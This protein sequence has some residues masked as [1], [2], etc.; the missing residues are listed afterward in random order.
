VSRPLASRLQV[1]LLGALV[2]IACF[3][4]LLFLV[5]AFIHPLNTDFAAFYALSRLGLT[6]GWGSLYDQVAEHEAWAAVGPMRFYPDMYP[7]T[8]S[9]LLAPVA[10]LPLRVAYALWTATSLG[11]LLWSWHTLAQGRLLTRALQLAAACALLP[12]G[13][14]IFLGQ[15]VIFI[16]AAITLAWRLLAAGRPYLAGLALAALSVKPQI[17]L[18]VPVALLLAGYGRTFLAG[19]G[20]GVVLLLL[21]WLTLGFDGVAAYVSHLSAGMAEPDRYGVAQGLSFWGLIGRGP[22]ALAAECGA[23]LLALIAAWRCRGG[24]PELPIAAGIVGSLVA[25][26][27]IHVQDAS[28]LLIAGW[29]TLRRRGSAFQMAILGSAYVAADLS[30]SVIG[31]VPLLAVEIVWLLDLVRSP[32]ARPQPRLIAQEA[33]AS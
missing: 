1:A 10:L 8:L 25:T 5:N 11:L 18:L 30:A 9:W 32:V 2:A 16:G 31:P 17:A 26:P 14:E 21:A 7:P 20:A 12:V 19:A 33:P 6:H 15:P 28:L 27:F 23:A 24:G 3:Q 22:L 13:L 4:L 29:L